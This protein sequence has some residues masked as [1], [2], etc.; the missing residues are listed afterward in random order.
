MFRSNALRRWPQV[1]MGAVFIVQVLLLLQSFYGKNDGE[2]LAWLSAAGLV[3]SLL[4][5]GLAWIAMAQARELAQRARDQLDEAIDALP[6]SVEIFDERDRMIAFNHRLV[7]IYPHML[8]EFERGAS[9][10]ELVRASL[11]RGGI[12]EAQGR[13]EAWIAE[14]KTVRGQQREALLQRVH[15]NKWLRIYERRMPGGGIVGVRMDVSDLVHEQQRLAASQAHLQALIHAAT[16]AIVTL[17]TSGHMLEV[18]PA[19]QHLFGFSAQ[20]M[21]GAHLSMLI[22]NAQTTAEQ[23][24]PEALLGRQR[25]F[26]A[27]H[28][29]GHELTVQMNVAEVK[30]ATTHLFVCIITDFSDRK[31]QEMRLREANALLARQSTTDG[32]TGVGN[33]RLFDQLLIQEWQRSARTGKPLALLLVDIDHFKQY[34]DHYGHVAGDDCLRRVASLLS[35]C[36]G[37]SI[38]SVCRYGGEEFVVLLVDTELE[39]AKV[40]AQRCLDSLRLAAIAHAA[41]PV[42]PWVSLSIGVAAC[43]ADV[44]QRPQT[45]VQDADAALYQAKQAGRARMVFGPLSA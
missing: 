31:R 3:L 9:F 42:R 8:R 22:G 10:E 27:R 32:L 14:R 23:L 16:N 1:A 2:A 41:S 17:D 40:V 7:E 37:R 24:Q 44:Q 36:V 43:V 5:G 25:E 33:R 6:A 28:R 20:E 18:N 21:Q 39:G 13:E 19:C 4:L 11:A 12:P 45:L 26:S 38:E 29:E 15:D 35:A 34:N 30:T